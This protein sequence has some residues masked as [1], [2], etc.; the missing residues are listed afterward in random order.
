MFVVN[1]WVWYSRA[2]KAYIWQ[3]SVF[4]VYSLAP[5]WSSLQAG[6]GGVMRG[7]EGIVQNDN[8]GDTIFSQILFQDS[9]ATRVK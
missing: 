8:C 3:L 5:S 7:L 1:V 6:V 4:S 2:A 9:T